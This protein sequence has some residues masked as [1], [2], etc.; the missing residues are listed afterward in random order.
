MNKKIVLPTLAIEMTR[1]CNMN[2]KFCDKGES[3]NLDISKSIIDQ[4]LDEVNRM[5]IHELRIFGGE[6]TLVPELIDY[7]VD[8]I[9]D[10]KTIIHNAVMFTN[11]NV[12]DESIALSFAKLLR[13]INSI[14]QDNLKYIRYFERNYAPVYEHRKHSKAV[15]VVSTIA[16][17]TERVSVAHDVKSYYEQLVPDDGFEVIIQNES[18]LSGGDTIFIEGNVL[19]HYKDVI[20]NPI[21]SSLIRTVENDYYFISENDSNAELPNA[22]FINKTILVSANGNVYPGCSTSYKR[23][24]QNPMFN[25]MDCHNTLITEI[26]QWCWQHPVSEY[27]KKLREKNHAFHFCRDNNISIVD[28]VTGKPLQ[29]D[30][31][32]MHDTCE[33][34]INVLETFNKQLHEFYPLATFDEIEAISVGLICKALRKQNCDKESIMKHMV[35]CAN[36]K[37]DAT[38]LILEHPNWVGSQVD[39]YYQKYNVPRNMFTALTDLNLMSL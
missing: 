36:Y 22:T 16:R 5:F 28:A 21:S 9:I 6:P 7:L 12:M 27:Q 2:C 4:T 17:D 10:R 37:S 11:G 13:Y 8:A 38:K 15:I 3:Q 23:V 19:D 25:I 26:K 30:I 18:F 39:R 1:R 29:D 35:L 14:E 34:L 31:M 20:P 33:N 24:D 32:A